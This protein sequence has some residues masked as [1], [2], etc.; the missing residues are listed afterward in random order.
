MSF[1]L[2]S[3]QRGLL[4]AISVVV[5]LGL[6]LVLSIIRLPNLLRWFGGLYLGGAIGNLYDRVLH[7]FVIDFF[8]IRLFRFAIFNVADTVMCAAVVYIA[9]WFLFEARH[10]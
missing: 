6:L 2:L 7:G 1:S 4:I 5:C 3:G 10:G 8:E 9:F